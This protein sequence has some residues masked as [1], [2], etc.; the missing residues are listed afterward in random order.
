M[1]DKEQLEPRINEQILRYFNNLPKLREVRL[2]DD[3]GNQ[4]GILNASKA[5]GMARE[6]DL[7]LV[8]I[9]PKAVP[10]V[11]KLVDYGKYKYQQAKK[12]KNILH[13]SKQSEIKTLTFGMTIEEHDF[14]VKINNALK[15]LSNKDK[16]KII[17]KFKGR[18]II[19]P[20]L[21]ERLVN[22][23]VESTSELSIV[24]KPAVLEGKSITFMLAPK[25]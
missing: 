5:L 20:E 17:I 12:Q 7:D 2:V 11:C 21:S 15:F 13:S 18:E 8:E 23:I 25:S 19:R 22:R 4:H 1:S 9:A 24:E 10:P 16:V 6:L 3:N 14:K